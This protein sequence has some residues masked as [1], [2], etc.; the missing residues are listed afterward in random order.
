[1]NGIAYKTFC[2]NPRLYLRFLLSSCIKLGAECR[3]QHISSMPA[4]LEAS[5]GES[6][7]AIFNCVGLGAGILGSDATVFPTKG[8]VVIVK[9][10]AKH[11]A[12][13]LGDG[14]EAVVIPRPGAD[15]TLLG[16]CR[17]ENDWYGSLLSFSGRG[18]RILTKCWC[19]SPDADEATTQ[20]ILDRC[21]PIAPHLLDERGDFKVL[22]VEVGLRPSRPLGPRIEVERL[23]AGA[24]GAI[25]TPLICHNYGHHSSG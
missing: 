6:I 3:T 19:R 4:L 8:Q 15:E 16:G 7:R 20:A 21:R 25:Q 22:R 13:R 24:P 1:M 9:G 11:A 14:F 5:R 18:L 23:H 2:I 17:I 12:T 10:H